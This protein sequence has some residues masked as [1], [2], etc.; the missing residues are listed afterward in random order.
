MYVHEWLDQNLQ[1]IADST[2]KAFV[3]NPGAMA[4][5][6]PPQVPYRAVPPYGGQVMEYGW[7]SGIQ[8]QW[9]LDRIVRPV[10]YAEQLRP[11]GAPDAM[12]REP[13]AELWGQR[14]WDLTTPAEAERKM[15]EGKDY[16]FILYEV[17]W[18]LIVRLLFNPP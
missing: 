12:L 16:T 7:K 13:F 15:S 5:L 2:Q 4:R 11:G 9:I 6:V 18:D 14:E 17:D 3:R 8:R 10:P 1:R